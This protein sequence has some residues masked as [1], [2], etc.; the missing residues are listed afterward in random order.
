MFVLFSLNTILYYWL[1]FSAVVF[2]FFSCRLFD[3]SLRTF[4][5]LSIHKFKSAVRFSLGIAV[6]IVEKQFLALF[7]SFYSIN[8]D[9]VF[10]VDAHHFRFTV[11]VRFGAVY[12]S[13]HMVLIRF[14]TLIIAD[15]PLKFSRYC[16]AS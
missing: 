16:L 11:W 3:V 6:T 7:D 4:Y 13:W 9:P 14:R 8:S 12:K 15:L 10:A 5:P 1:F 2:S